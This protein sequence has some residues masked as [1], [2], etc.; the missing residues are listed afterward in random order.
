MNLHIPDHPT[1]KVQP[2]VFPQLSHDV[3]VGL[4]FLREHRMVVD[5]SQE[6]P[7]LRGE[8]GQTTLIATLNLPKEEFP[9]VFKGDQ[10]V[11]AG[12]NQGCS[13]PR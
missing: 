11:P 4:Q 9:V 3:N 13:Q 10:P 2:L 6:T 5:Y 12:Q 1:F 7:V 8:S